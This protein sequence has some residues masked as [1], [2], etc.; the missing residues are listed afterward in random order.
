MYSSLRYSL[1]PEALEPIIILEIF[2]RG[3]TRRNRGRRGRIS[4]APQ[5]AFSSPEGYRMGVMAAGGYWGRPVLQNS[6]GTLYRGVFRPWRPSSSAS[7]EIDPSRMRRFPLGLRGSAIAYFG[8]TVDPILRPVQLVS[9]VQTIRINT[10]LAY[11]DSGTGMSGTGM[12]QTLIDEGG[13]AE[14]GMATLGYIALG[15][16]ALYLLTKK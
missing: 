16:G 11:V 15:A 4:V 13:G 1:S 10:S 9:G 14:S 2:V 8:A 6:R 7:A 12:G 3:Y 5:L